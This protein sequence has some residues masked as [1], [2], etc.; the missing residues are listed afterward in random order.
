MT[1]KEFNDKM[2]KVQLKNESKIRK[3]QLREMKNQC[4]QRKKIQT[5]KLF[6]ILL[7]LSCFSTQ[8]YSMFVMYHFGN[9]DHLSTLIGSTLAEGIGLIGYFAK[10]YCESREEGRLEF[11]KEKFYSEKSSFETEEFYEEES[12]G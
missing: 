8:V 10:S 9:L 11:E 5:S 7:F 6:F 2:K 1:E 4:K 12:V 3:Q